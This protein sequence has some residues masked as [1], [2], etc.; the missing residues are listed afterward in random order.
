LFGEK[1]VEKEN[2]NFLPKKNVKNIFQELCFQKIFFMS[3]Q[4]K[5]LKEFCVKMMKF[6][7]IT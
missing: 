5:C 4:E 3:S 6:Y 7:C 1:K 2:Q